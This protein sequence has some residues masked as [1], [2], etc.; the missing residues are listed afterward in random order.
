[1]KGDRMLVGNDIEADRLRAAISSNKAP[2]RGVEK[3][4][5]LGRALRAGRLR[6]GRFAG[7]RPACTVRAM[8]RARLTVR[9]P[10]TTP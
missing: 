4:T 2:Y 9:S 6:A 7:G 3:R 5:T 1:M 8:P 10:L